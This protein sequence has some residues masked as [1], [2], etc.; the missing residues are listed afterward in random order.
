MRWRSYA[1]V[2]WRNDE[3]RDLPSVDAE[4]VLHLPGE[5]V[6]DNDGEVHSPRHQR[7]LVVA[8][9]DLIW[10]QDAGHLVAVAS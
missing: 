2:F 7:A 9:R 4:D 6:P 1:A 5:N 10:V 3:L 8:W